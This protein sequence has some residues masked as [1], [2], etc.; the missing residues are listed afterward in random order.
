MCPFTEISFDKHTI[1]RYIN[2]FTMYQASDDRLTIQPIH[3]LKAGCLYL[4]VIRKGLRSA[5][6][7]IIPSHARYANP[8]KKYTPLAMDLA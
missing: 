2:S 6:G 1:N 5:Q 7:E 4:A 8:Y 3:P